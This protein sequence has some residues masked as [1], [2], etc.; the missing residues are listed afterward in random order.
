MQN[1]DRIVDAS[2]SKGINEKTK[3]LWWCGWIG[4]VAGLVLISEILWE[5]VEKIVFNLFDLAVVSEHNFHHMKG[6]GNFRFHKFR[7]KVLKVLSVMQ[8]L[9]SENS[10][11]EVWLQDLWV[12]NSS[13]GYKTQTI[14]TI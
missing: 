9:K 10:H 3:P 7:K 4:S 13:K 11:R 14:V 2:L 8:G 6:K 12:E 1:N 5:V